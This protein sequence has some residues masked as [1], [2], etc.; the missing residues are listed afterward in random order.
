MDKE[1]APELVSHD[2]NRTLLIGGGILLVVLAAIFGLR[3]VIKTSV[4][5]D[6][7]RLAT[8]EVGPVEN[9]LNATGEVIPAFEQG[10][11]QST[12]SISFQATTESGR[13]TAQ[14]HPLVCAGDSTRRQ[15]SV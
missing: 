13:H 1:L 5:A 11:Y 4:D 8:A 2:R 12:G 9:T 7:I 14:F 15:H 6:K 10:H 3:D